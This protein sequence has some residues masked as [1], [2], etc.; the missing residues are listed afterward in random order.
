MSKNKFSALTECSVKLLSNPCKV[1]CKKKE[2]ERVTK[3]KQTL[4]KEIH[5]IKK[6]IE[7]GN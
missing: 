5:N 1:I 2:K 7:K 4:Q 3:E 6:G